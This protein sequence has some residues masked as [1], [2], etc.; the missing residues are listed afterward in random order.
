MWTVEVYEASDGTVPY[1]RFIAALTDAKFAALDAAVERVLAVRGLDL[2]STEWLKAL[3]GGLHEFRVRH[4]A[5]EIARMF[6][7][8]GVRTAKKRERILLRVFVHFYGKRVILLLGGY[9]KGADPKERRQQRE[10]D[11]ARKLLAEFR[12][13]QQPSR[14]GSDR[15]LG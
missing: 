14:R 8:D 3:G 12:E 2:A 11:R 15:L 4:D 9:D 13:R 1:E 6:G 7:E 5:D 10:I